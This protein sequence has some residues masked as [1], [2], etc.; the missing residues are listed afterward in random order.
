MG[1]FPLA[2]LTLTISNG[3]KNMKRFAMDMTGRLR[4]V[5]MHKPANKSF[6]GYFRKLQRHCESSWQACREQHASSRCHNSRLL[7]CAPRRTGEGAFLLHGGGIP[8]WSWALPATTQTAHC[9]SQ[10]EC[11]PCGRLFTGFP[12]KLPKDRATSRD[13]NR[14]SDGGV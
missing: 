5:D 13:R 12:A 2:D 3:K 14:E 4:Q 6:Y 1:M 11:D 8:L 7:P 10:G 9:H